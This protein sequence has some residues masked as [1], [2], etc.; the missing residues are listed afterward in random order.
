MGSSFF[1]T[2]F[3]LQGIDGFIA[4]PSDFNRL[5]NII[6]SDESISIVFIEE[7]LYYANKDKL[8]DL[9]SSI[10]RPLFVEIPSD[11]MEKHG[12]TDLIAELIKKK[13]GIDIT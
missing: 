1:V 6:L 10:K 12:D 8:D 5:I 9:K 11:N 4:A 7:D 13:I 2:G 3:K